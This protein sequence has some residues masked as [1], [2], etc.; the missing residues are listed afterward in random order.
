MIAAFNTAYDAFDTLNSRR[1]SGLARKAELTK[2]EE[3]A[4][5]AQLE[6]KALVQAHPTAKAIDLNKL[7]GD[8]LT[9]VLIEETRMTR[10]ATE[11]TAASL[12]R[13]AVS[14]ENIVELAHS[15]RMNEPTKIESR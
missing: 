15:V 10:F 13:I 6:L 11:Q 8:A 3:A 1:T 2:L 5:T 7:A 14:F 9:R 12:D 4:A